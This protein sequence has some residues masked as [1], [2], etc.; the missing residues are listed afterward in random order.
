MKNPYI[1]HI[2]T[3]HCLRKLQIYVYNYIMLGMGVPTWQV[4][5]KQMHTTFSH[6][7]SDDP[8]S[9]EP[10]FKNNELIQ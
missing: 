5:R 3:S 6:P 9:I 10:M 7:N 8:G 2:L 1:L 4:N